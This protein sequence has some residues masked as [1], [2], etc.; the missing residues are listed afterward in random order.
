V[1]SGHRLRHISQ[2]FE[3]ATIAAI[4][5]EIITIVRADLDKIEQETGELAE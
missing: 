2:S 5:E 1:G 3:V 4:A